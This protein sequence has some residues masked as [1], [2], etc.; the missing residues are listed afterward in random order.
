MSL[1][2]TY[3]VLKLLIPM[4]CETSLHTCTLIF[5]LLEHHDMDNSN[6][7]LLESGLSKSFQKNILNPS[8]L[9]F[10]K[11]QHLHC[12]LCLCLEVVPN[13]LHVALVVDYG[14]KRPT[15]WTVTNLGR[16]H[17]LTTLQIHQNYSYYPI[18]SHSSIAKYSEESLQVHLV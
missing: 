17:H 16:T 8:T 2:F 4:Q 9:R 11:N 13:N 1:A 6:Q 7:L 14:S 10:L 5:H 18:T 12:T 3:M 15:T